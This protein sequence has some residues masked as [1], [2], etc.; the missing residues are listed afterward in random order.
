MAGRTRTRFELDL[1]M[2]FPPGILRKNL[3]VKKYDR[4]GRRFK[5]GELSTDYADFAD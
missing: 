3:D 2:E 1:C 4:V 5:W